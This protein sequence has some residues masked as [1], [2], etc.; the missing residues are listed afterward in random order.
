MTGFPPKAEVH[1][2]S[3]YVAQV[4][5]TDTTPRQYSDYV[6]YLVR[7]RPRADKQSVESAS[8]CSVTPPS[9]GPCTLGQGSGSSLLNGPQSASVIRS[10]IAVRVEGRS[11]HAFPPIGDPGIFVPQSGEIQDIE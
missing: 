7:G 6:R 2:R 9:R 11:R 3:C 5:L 4:P 1:Q 10:R 8:P